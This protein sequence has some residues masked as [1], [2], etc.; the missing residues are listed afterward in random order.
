MIG[1]SKKYLNY[2]KQFF[3]YLPRILKRAKAKLLFPISCRGHKEK[4]IRRGLF[5]PIMVMNAPSLQG[6]GQ[7][8]GLLF[9]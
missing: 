4:F 3:G 9:I 5:I 6:K 2:V 1:D 8:G 7:G